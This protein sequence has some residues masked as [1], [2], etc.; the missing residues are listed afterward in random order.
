MKK[1]LIDNALESW[2]MAIYYCDQ[3]MEGK[4]TL[5]NRKYFVSSLQNA[6]EL[7]LKQRMLDMCDYRVAEFCLSDSNGEPLR[8]YLSTKDLNSYFFNEYK[9]ACAKRSPRTI[10][11]NKI[12]EIHGEILGDFYREKESNGE[13]SENNIKESLNVLRRIR[14]DET[15]FFIDADEF[16]SEAQFQTLYNLMVDFYKVLQFFELLPFWGE[17]FG[18]YRRFGFDR[19]VLT[20]FSY[21]KQLKNSEFVKKLKEIVEKEVFLD[22]EEDDSYFI[23][24]DIINYCDAYDENDF[25]ELWLYIQMLMRYN[26]LQ[27]TKKHIEEHGYDRGICTLAIKI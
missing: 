22:Y 24:N 12:I 2:S 7:F 6:I 20:D 16:L 25:D 11:F 27:I 4:A 26:L 14:N 10:G 13:S 23:A 8:S 18:E 17:P 1:I 21:K 15:H 9:D 5:L 3:I 19:E